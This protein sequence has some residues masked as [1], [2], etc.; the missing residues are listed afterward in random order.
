MKFDTPARDTHLPRAATVSLRSCLLWSEEQMHAGQASM[1]NDYFSEI[2]R[3]QVGTCRFHTFPIETNCYDR[4]YADDSAQKR[5]EDVANEDG[6]SMPAR[7]KP[8]NLHVL[9]GLD[10]VFRNRGA[11]RAKPCK[12]NFHND[13]PNDQPHECAACSDCKLI[14]RTPHVERHVAMFAQCRHPVLFELRDQRA[15]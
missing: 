2:W 3:S 5:A 15:D 14:N 9:P 4:P 7:S 12:S 13:I 11:H 6:S 1:R 8:E 10:Q